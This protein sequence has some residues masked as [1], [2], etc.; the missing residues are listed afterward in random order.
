MEQLPIS[1]ESN[2][3]I[4][5]QSASGWCIH[6]F[7]VQIQWYSHYFFFP[8][9]VA[10]IEGCLRPTFF[11][12]HWRWCRRFCF[13][14]KSFFFFLSFNWLWQKK[15]LPKFRK[16]LKITVSEWQQQERKT[17]QPA[18]LASTKIS[19]SHGVT[20]AVFFLK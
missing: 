7:L 11:S 5:F 4:S 9:S 6:S 3:N 2:K 14:F 16:K 20:A 8:F 15:N 18:I 17:E 10:E 13:L 19:H 12:N 1:K